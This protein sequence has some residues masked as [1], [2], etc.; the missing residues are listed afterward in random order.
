[1]QKHFKFILFMSA[2]NIS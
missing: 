1:M 2:W